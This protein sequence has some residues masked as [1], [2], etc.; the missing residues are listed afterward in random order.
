[1][2]PLITGESQGACGCWLLPLILYVRLISNVTLTCSPTYWNI[3]H[4]TKQVLYFRRFSKIFV[5]TLSPISM[6][7]IQVEIYIWSLGY[8]AIMISTIDY[9]NTNIN[10]CYEYITLQL[11]HM[12]VILSQVMGNSTVVL[13]VLLGATKKHRSLALLAFLSGETT[14]NWTGVLPNNHPVA[15][16]KQV[17]FTWNEIYVKYGDVLQVLWTI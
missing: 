15:S 6:V 13:T 11:R 16:Y 3:W 12:S 8:A 9:N 1:M 5:G 14:G 4:F 7:W 17:D 2:T 10:M